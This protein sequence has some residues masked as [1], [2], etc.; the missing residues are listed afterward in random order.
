MAL[1]APMSSLT[2]VYARTRTLS[3]QKQEWHSSPAIFETRTTPSWNKQSTPECQITM[4]LR[5]LPRNLLCKCLLNAIRDFRN[6]Q[7]R[8]VHEKPLD[9][10][11]ASSN[12]RLVQ[13]ASKLQFL[14]TYDTAC[15]SANQDEDPQTPTS[16]NKIIQ[17][18]C[19]IRRQNWTSNVG[20]TASFFIRLGRNSSLIVP[21][22][23][24][25]RKALKAAVNICINPQYAVF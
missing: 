3:N 17:T 19:E 10:L 5:P 6:N 9:W 4:D 18:E 23:L 14:P 2:A 24:M 22:I 8:R 12:T 21:L 7:I 13:D 20:K 15:T 25:R 1:L 16:G 11:W